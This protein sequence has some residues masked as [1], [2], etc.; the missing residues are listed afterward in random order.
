MSSL[1]SPFCER[2]YC[3]DFMAGSWSI[4]RSCWVRMTTKNSRERVQWLQLGRAEP[5]VKHWHPSGSLI[6]T[7]T[8]KN[9]QSFFWPELSLF[10]SHTWG[11]YF[12]IFGIR[13][14][15][16]F[17]WQV[18]KNGPQNVREKTFEAER[19]TAWQC[20]QVVK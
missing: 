1:L 10:F 11:C 4:V 5:Q 20:S 15:A 16:H 9:Q 8:Q 17:Y 14:I 12:S 18:G 3:R 19:F 6:V 13:Q 2:Q 7:W